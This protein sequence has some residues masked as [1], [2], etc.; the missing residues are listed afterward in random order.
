MVYDH[1]LKPTPLISTAKHLT[2]R[3]VAN[4]GSA[5]TVNEG[6]SVTLNG[7]GSTDNIAIESYGWSSEIPTLTLTNADADTANF[8]APEVDI[9]GLE[10]ILNPYRNRYCRSYR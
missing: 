6:D 7:T 5:Q 4:A 1:K 2:P 8:T 3:P 9:S 10:I